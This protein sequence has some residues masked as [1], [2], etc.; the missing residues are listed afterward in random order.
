MPNLT[1]IEKLY[2]NLLRSGELFKIDASMSGFISE[3]W[4]KFITY[5]KKSKQ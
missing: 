4:D 2:F 5:Y 1:E 3:D